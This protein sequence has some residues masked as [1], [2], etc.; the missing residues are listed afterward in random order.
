MA[1]DTQSGRSPTRSVVRR[2]RRSSWRSPAILLVLFL[3]AHMVGNLKIFFGAPAF[4]HYA[5]WLRTIGSRCCRTEWYLW[6]QRGVLTVAAVRAHLRRPPS[7]PA[8]P[9]GPARSG[10]RTG[11]RCRAATRPAR[12]AGAA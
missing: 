9:G 8:A 1:V 12:C 2:A 10:T 11:R 3:F 5:H 4:D 6:I 7:W